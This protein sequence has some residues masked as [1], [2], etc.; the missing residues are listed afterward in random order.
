MKTLTNQGI[1]DYVLANHGDTLGLLGGV[2]RIGRRDGDVF[3]VGGAVDRLGAPIQALSIPRSMFDAD[4]V[5]HSIDYVKNARRG[6]NAD[7]HGVG[8]WIDQ[9]NPEVVVVD[10]I[11]LIMGE[12]LATAVAVERGELAIWSLQREAEVRF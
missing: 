9:D 4:A 12:A 5:Q 1:A 10:A 2:H 3:S 8:F 11:D 6:M 7:W